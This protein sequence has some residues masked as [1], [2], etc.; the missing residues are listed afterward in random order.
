MKPSEFFDDFSQ[1]LLKWRNPLPGRDLPWA[2]EP[3][4]Y[5]VWISEIMLQQPQ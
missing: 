5:K 4:P 2:F 1:L 3:N